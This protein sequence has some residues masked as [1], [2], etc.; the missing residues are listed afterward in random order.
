MLTKI[1][2]LLLMMPF[3]VAL[4]LTILDATKKLYILSHTS[5]QFLKI[6]LTIVLFTECLNYGLYLLIR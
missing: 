1:L 2:G 5:I 6:F 3:L 4:W